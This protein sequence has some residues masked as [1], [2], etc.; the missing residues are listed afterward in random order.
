[1]EALVAIAICAELVWWLFVAFVLKGVINLRR[2]ID[3][4]PIEYL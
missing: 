4:I 1:M 3:K 2:D